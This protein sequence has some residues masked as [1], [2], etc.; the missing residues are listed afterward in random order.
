MD[1]ESAIIDCKTPA[2]IAVA[3]GLP[4]VKVA[5][6]PSSAVAEA[7]REIMDS[8]ISIADKVAFGYSEVTDAIPA[9]NA[10]INSSSERS[11]P[12]EAAGFSVGVGGTSVFDGLAVLGLLTIDE[13]PF[14]I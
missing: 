10:D 12:V 5:I 6:T 1:E 14:D 3:D 8:I 9:D 7:A 4:E 11:P 13:F 2:A